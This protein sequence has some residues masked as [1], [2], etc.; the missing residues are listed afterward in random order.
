[1][2]PNLYTAIDALISAV[3]RGRSRIIRPI[4]VPVVDRRRSPIGPGLKVEDLDLCTESQECRTSQAWVPL[5]IIRMPHSHER[6]TDDAPQHLTDNSGSACSA[7]QDVIRRP[8]VILLHPT[9][10]NMDWQRSKQED[11]ARGGYIAAAID[12]RYHGER[13]QEVKGQPV[14]HV[15]EDALIRA[16]R[17]G[18][19]R[20]FLL[21]NIWDIMHL[22]DYLLT[23]PDVDPSRVGI[24]GYSLGGMHAWLA[25]VADPRIAVVAAVSG[26]QGFEYAIKNKV[27]QGRVDS[28]SHFFAAVATDLGQSKVE[29]STV[30]KAWDR[31]APGLVGSFDAPQSLPCIAP[32]P[33]MVATG[34]VDPRCPLQG[35]L[36]ACHLTRPLYVQ[37]VT[38]IREERRQIQLAIQKAEEEVLLARL[39]QQEELRVAQQKAEEEL[40]LELQRQ[41]EEKAL[42]LKRQQ[43]LDNEAAILEG[44]AP[45]S[46]EPGTCEMIIARHEAKEEESRGVVRGNTSEEEDASKKLNPSSTSPLSEKEDTGE[47]LAGA[48]AQSL[49]LAEEK[50][51]GHEEEQPREMTL[52]EKLKYAEEEM[53]R[54]QEARRQRSLEEEAEKRRLRAERIEAER[55]RLAAE[56]AAEKERQEMEADVRKLM[57][58]YVEPGVGHTETASMN[59]AVREF[60][61]LYLLH[62]EGLSESSRRNQ[63]M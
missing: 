2:D 32:R 29:A 62:G 35:V 38:G 45:G 36:E 11:Y 22:V 6:G 58:V 48:A 42:E 44:D 57:V 40:Q 25:G 13:A 10:T 7:E 18:E 39:K 33:L 63:F 51:Q 3:C 30:K 14:R 43:S 37:H 60:M 9:G 16:W 49:D 52:M 27:F 26:V 8:A 34:E 56:A 59:K 17:G 5:R 24:T 31:V 1:M 23:R 47:T 50:K 4:V 54:E 19:E 55:R 28:L 61:D 41:K 15:Y 20:P 21:D 12:C 46:G 53:A